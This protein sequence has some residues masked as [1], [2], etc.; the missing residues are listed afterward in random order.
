MRGPR[1]PYTCQ[2]LPR[3]AHSRFLPHLCVRHVCLPPLPVQCPIVCKM[4]LATAQYGTLCVAMLSLAWPC[5]RFHAAASSVAHAAKCLWESALRLKMF[6][7]AHRRGLPNPCAMLTLGGFV[8]GPSFVAHSVFAICEQDLCLHPLQ[9]QS[10]SE[11]QN[12]GESC[13]ATDV[14]SHNNLSASITFPSCIR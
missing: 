3:L 7:A 11:M 9:E 5:F 1:Q 12:V 14:Q 10:R 6:C 2:T 4:L 13:I 8:R